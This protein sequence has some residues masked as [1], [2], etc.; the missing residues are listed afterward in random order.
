MI[1]STYIKDV[2]F[3]LFTFHFLL[4]HLNI[5]DVLTGFYV[6]RVLIRNYK[7]F[8]NENFYDLNTDFLNNIKN[9]LNNLLLHPAVDDK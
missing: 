5:P 2:Q 7:A 8:E 4:E 6:E 1:S 3:S 9:G